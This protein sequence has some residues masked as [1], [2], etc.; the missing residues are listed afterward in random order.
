MTDFG[1]YIYSYGTLARML[2][3]LDKGMS[4]TTEHKL[5]S[6]LVENANLLGLAV[7]VKQSKLLVCRSTTG[8]RNLYVDLVVCLF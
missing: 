4:T 1:S 7:I 5:S 6:S 3:L 2:H 8:Q